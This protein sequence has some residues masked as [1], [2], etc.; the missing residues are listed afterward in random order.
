LGRLPIAIPVR[1]HQPKGQ[2]NDPQSES[3]GL[4]PGRGL[5]AWR[6]LGLGRH[7]EVNAV[8]DDDVVPLGLVEKDRGSVAA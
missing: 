1:E 2:Q 8:F 6:N 5:R 4:G 7:I 3:P